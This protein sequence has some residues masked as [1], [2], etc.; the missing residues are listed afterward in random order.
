MSKKILITGANGFLGS[1]L[2][3]FAKKKKFNVRALVRDGSDISNLEKL[4]VEIFRGDLRDKYSINNAVKSCSI[5]FHAA[6]DY[7]LWAKKK[8]EIYESNVLGTQNLIDAIKNIKNHKMVYTSSVATIGLGEKKSNEETPV[9]FKDMVG[10]Y[11]KSKYLAEK[12]VENCV[13]KEELNCVIVNPSTPIGPGDIKPTPTGMVI[14]QM[15]RGK[16]P[17]YVETGLN[18]VHVDDV[19]NG[20]FLALQK[21]LVGN[22]YILGGENMSFKDF[23]DLIAEYGEVPKTNFR[24][25]TSPLYPFAYMNEILGST[26]KDY[27]PMLTLDGLKMS[28][29]K[30][31]FSSEKAKKNLGYRP[32]NVKD[33][34]KESVMWMKQFFLD[35][36]K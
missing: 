8:S 2:T 14:L 26:L 12:L 34:I 28:E 15:L 25:S 21:G 7:R 13:R 3:R 17:A 32:R 6:A 9:T 30:M 35:K 4:N 5:F 23:L 27:E 18:F 11:K 36:S 29:K 24:I 20:H 10:D 22:K 1:A 33:A 19:A 31:F 16:M